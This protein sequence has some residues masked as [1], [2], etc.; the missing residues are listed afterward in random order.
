M[1]F[2][3]KMRLFQMDLKNTEKH[4]INTHMY[5]CVFIKGR[6]NGKI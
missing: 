4:T 1:T 6:G 3:E 5:L 2:L